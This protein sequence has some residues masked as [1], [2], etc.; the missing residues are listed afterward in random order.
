MANIDGAQLWLPGIRQ[1]L[2]TLEIRQLVRWRLVGLDLRQ[3]VREA[4][5]RARARRRRGMA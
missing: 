5:R 1:A 2:S 4:R 3:A